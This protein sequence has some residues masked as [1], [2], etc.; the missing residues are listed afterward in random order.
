MT[1]LRRHCGLLADANANDFVESVR[2]E[3]LHG[4]SS[5]A[6]LALLL[7]FG[8]LVGLIVV[9]SRMFRSP[10]ALAPLPRIDLL[11]EA[12]EV[13]KLSAGERRDIGLLAH[14][15]GHSQPAAMLLSPANLSH[16]LALA[17]SAHPD[18]RLTGH[19]NSLCIRLHGVPL[20]G[21]RDVPGV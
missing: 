12:A 9:L 20:P 6:T 21:T 17:N 18:P 7:A 13:L 16:A 10:E 1:G 4:A 3:L 11:R 2:E 19:I 14:R 15:C 8:A 5:Q